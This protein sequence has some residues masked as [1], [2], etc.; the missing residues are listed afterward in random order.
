MEESHE[1]GCGNFSLAEFAI[2]FRKW[3][4]NGLNDIR[5]VDLQTIS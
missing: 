4:N 1:E 5:K 3:K 2:E